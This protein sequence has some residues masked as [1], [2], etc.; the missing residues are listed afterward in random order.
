MKLTTN[1]RTIDGLLYGV[2]VLELEDNGF[3]FC[4]YGDSALAACRTREEAERRVCVEEKA[5]KDSGA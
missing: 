1:E 4:T 3:R 5:G 2:V